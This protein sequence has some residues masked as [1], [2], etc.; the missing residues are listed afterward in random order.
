M[1]EKKRGRWKIET[2]FQAKLWKLIDK[3]C[4]G[5]WTVFADGAGIPHGTFRNYL[6]GVAEPKMEIFE[7]LC[8][9]ANVGPAY[10]KD[11]H[12][13][14]VDYTQASEAKESLIQSEEDEYGPRSTETLLFM[15]KEILNSDTSY[16]V[17]L[18][19]NIECFYKALKNE[20]K[21]LDHEKRI[22]A[23]E[24]KRKGRW[25]GATKKVKS[26]KQKAM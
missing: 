24:R 19:A 22:E 4:E 26:T 15:T 9:F 20:K 18:R 6:R 10:F 23:L 17:S 25:A 7:K 21:L 2:T 5:H 13:K 14:K 12:S 11:T 8:Q 1:N 16:S 3:C